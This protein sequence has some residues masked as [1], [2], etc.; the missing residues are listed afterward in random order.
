MQ[1]ERIL[2]D[3][4]TQV[5][6]LKARCIPA[7]FLGSAQA[8]SAVT[9]DAWAGKYLFVYIT[10]ELAANRTAELQKLRQKHVRPVAALWALAAA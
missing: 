3:L 5:L 4:A 9:A 7:C 8:S 2:P 6:A 1:G 10:P